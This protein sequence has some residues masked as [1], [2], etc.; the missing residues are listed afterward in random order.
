MIVRL[1][2]LKIAPD[3]V[4]DFLALIAT[5]RIEIGGAEGCSFLEILEDESEP[6]VFVTHSHWE[7]ENALNRY[8]RSE[9]FGQ[10]WPAIKLLLIDKPT[11]RSFQR[12][13]F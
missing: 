10:V 2:T 1:V 5:Y 6:G 7:D 4:D 9:L 11:A 13:I 8:R 3:R 12:K